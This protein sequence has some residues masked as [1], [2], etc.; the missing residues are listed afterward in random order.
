MVFVGPVFPEKI[1]A[2]ATLNDLTFVGAENLIYVTDRNVIVAKIELKKDTITS[3]EVLGE[4]LVVSGISTIYMFNIKTYGIIILI[5]YFIYFIVL[6]HSEHFESKLIVGFLHP[7][8]YLNKILIGFSNGELILYNINTHKTIHSFLEFAGKPL[9]LM[10]G[11]PDP[12]IVALGFVNG[13]ISFFEL[14]KAQILFNLKIDGAVSAFAFR[15]DELAHFAAG[16]A[17]GDVHVFDLESQK[18]EHIIPIHSKSVSSLFFVPRQ[19]LLISTSGDNSIKEY[20]FESSEYRCLRQRSGHYKSPNG[21]RFYGEDARFIVSSGNDRSIRFSS[22]FKDNQNF[23]F[24]QGSVQKTAAK[25]KIS[26]EEAK[27]SEVTSIDIF[28]TKTLKWDNM[29]T[30]HKDS[31][32]AKTWRFD[33]KTIGQHSLETSDKSIITHISISSCGNFGLVSTCSGMIDIFNL[34]SGLKRRS[35]KAFSETSIIS[36]FTDSSNTQIISISSSGEIKSFEFSKGVQIGQISTNVSVSSASINRDTELIAIGCS[37]YAIR[38][39]DFSAMKLVRLFNGHSAKVVDLIFSSDSKWIVSCSEDKSIRTWD[40]SSGNILDVLVVEKTPIAIA[41]SHNLEFLAS[42]H[43][44]EISI[45]LW[46]NRSLYTGDCNIIESAINCFTSSLSSEQQCS[47]NIQFSELPSS[48][49]KNIYFLEK[50]RGNT[51]P[52]QIL[53]TK[54]KDLPFFLSQSL[55]QDKLKKEIELDDVATISDISSEEFSERIMQFI[56]GGNEHQCF[57]FLKSIHP[58][59][60]DFEISCIPADVK[61]DYLSCILKSLNCTINEGKNFEISQSILALTLRHHENFICNNR[62]I[63]N[64]ILI[65]ISESI[66]SKWLPMEELMQSTICLVSF[67]RDQ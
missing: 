43:K 34:Q 9:T 53:S 46:S 35:I 37:D 48:R 15:S 32:K 57:S 29:L 36:S 40:M 5:L 3:L 64:E 23:E 49:W 12:D 22:I 54:R 62:E 20:L 25:L 63:F 47:S 28:G 60:L 14:K 18:L 6:V 59:K 33:R 21:I 8:T 42:C 31:S 4:T 19:P 1:S 24:S 61:P 30:S 52:S 13:S 17:L 55:E 27:L 7:E 45:K 38:V 58:S 44:D 66:K 65:N 10:S 16:S 56:D 2:L 39:I 26:E 41:L 51:K 67:S 11:S 50:I